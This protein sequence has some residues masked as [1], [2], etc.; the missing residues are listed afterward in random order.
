[1]FDMPP[2]TPDTMYLCSRGYNLQD[3][4]ESIQEKWP[5]ITFDEVSI[6]AEHH[7]VKCFGYDLYDPSDY[8]NFVVI[9]AGPEYF[10]RM[11]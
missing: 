1:M 4:L 10:D 11:K 5:E 7:Q 9:V 3:L 2:D 8:L 6:S